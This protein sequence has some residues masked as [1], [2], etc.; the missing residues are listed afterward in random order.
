MSADADRGLPISDE[1]FSQLN[2][3]QREMYTAKLARFYDYLCEE[4]KDPRK[5]LGYSDSAAEARIYR[6]QQV[7]KWLWK[8]NVPVTEITAEDGDEI[9]EALY[10]DRIC[11]TDEEPYA[12]GSKRK[13]NDVL[14]NWFAFRGIDWQPEYEFSDD[15]PKK[16]NK[17][18]PFLK[19]ELVLL[20]ETS[21]TYKSIPSYNNL[22][23]AERD[24]WKSYIAQE[25]GKPKAEVRP[26]D[27]EQINNDWKIPSLVRTS[28]SHG[29]RPDMVGRMKV[30]WYDPDTQT[31]YI[32]TGEA[33][34][35]DACWQ[36]ELAEEAAHALD[37]W[38]EQRELMEL[39]D[40]REEIWLTRQGNPYSSKSLKDLLDNLIEEAEIDTRGR[41]LVWTSFRHSIGTYVFAETKSLR[42]VADQLRQKSRSSAEWYIHSLPELS[43]ELAE[44]M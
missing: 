26:A 24:D 1:Q 25:L 5:G 36:V 30:D 39:Y 32:P 13:F 44:L 22:S 12:E 23:P 8:F 34:K 33:T 6:F 18:D 10:E 42:L 20:W 7:V 31:I 38:L 15:D 27:W 28:R 11:K 2:V 37:N 16:E 14:N 4:G 9:N 43:R 29:W 41:K 35:N 3:R 21:L 17:P 19:H 40:N